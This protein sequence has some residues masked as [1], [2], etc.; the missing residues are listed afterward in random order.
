MERIHNIDRL[1]DEQLSTDEL[2]IVK[3][4]IDTDEIRP[5]EIVKKFNSNR[6]TIWAKLNKIKNK[7]AYTIGYKWN[8]KGFNYVEKI[9]CAVEGKAEN[10][11]GTGIIMETEYFEKKNITVITAYIKDNFEENFLMI[12]LE[13]EKQLFYV[14]RLL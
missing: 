6:M 5:K 11:I 1:K 8:F 13:K 3:Y 4:L 2:N 10:I 12:A 7:G 14:D 9:I